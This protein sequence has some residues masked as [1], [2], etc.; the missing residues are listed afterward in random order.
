MCVVAPLL[1]DGRQD[2]QPA[3]PGLVPD[4]LTYRRR[5]LPWRSPITTGP[6]AEYASHVCTQTG[7]VEEMG[8]PRPKRRHQ[9][10]NPGKG[11]GRRRREQAKE[12]G[13]EG[14]GQ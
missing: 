4:P 5:A 11:R 10:G 7:W 13:D 3:V 8:A 6:G 14:E 2:K 1:R 12:K 9:T